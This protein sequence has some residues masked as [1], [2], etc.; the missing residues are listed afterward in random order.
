VEVRD[1]TGA[2]RVLEDVSTDSSRILSV[3]KTV[4][5]KASLPERFFP[6]SPTTRLIAE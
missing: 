5:K 3:P 1:E 4:I 6:P 2:H